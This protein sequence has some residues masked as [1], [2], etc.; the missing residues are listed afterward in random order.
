[1]IKHFEIEGDLN[2]FIPALYTEEVDSTPVPV[3]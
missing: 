1:M 3:Y 2:Y